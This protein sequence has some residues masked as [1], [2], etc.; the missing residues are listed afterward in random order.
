MCTQPLLL[1]MY[2]LTTVHGIYRYVYVYTQIHVC[3]KIDLRGRLPY[4]HLPT[5]RVLVR[6]GS[7]SYA[8]R[9]L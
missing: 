1:S 9:Y 3:K 2:W 8:S 5:L 4:L 7:F 6:V